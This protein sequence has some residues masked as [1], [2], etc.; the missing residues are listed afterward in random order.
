MLKVQSVVV[1]SDPILEA[2]ACK[3]HGINR[4]PPIEQ[5]RMIARA[6]EQNEEREE[7]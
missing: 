2:V 5:K 6:A 4:V 7:S 3:L 1:E